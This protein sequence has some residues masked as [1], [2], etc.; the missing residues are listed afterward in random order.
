M[1]IFDIREPHFMAE[2]EIH[3]FSDS[4]GRFLDEHA[5][6]ERTAKWRADGQVEREFWREA[7]Q[8]SLLG[9]SIPQAIEG[10]GTA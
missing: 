10:F 8:A 4:V 7:G 3:M 2:P 6:P 5:P 1:P 9:I